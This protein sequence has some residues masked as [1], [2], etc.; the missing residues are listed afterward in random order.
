MKILVL[1]YSF[2]ASAKQITFTDY[3][4]IVVERVLLITNITDNIIIYNFADPAKGGTAATN[5]LTLTYDTGTMS[6]TDKLQIFYDDAATTQPVS[7]TVTANLSATDNT[8]L[9]NIDTKTPALGQALAA[10]STPVVLTA[11]QITTLTPPAQGLTDAQ[12]RATAVP[13]SLASVP[14][15]AVT[16]AGTFAVQSTNQANS[17]VDIG[18]VTINNS[19]GAAAVNIQ[20]GGNTI[21]VDGTV[22]VTNADLTTLAG[23]VSATHMQTDVLTLPANASVNVAQINGVTT[24]MGAGNTGTG[25]QRVTIASDQ[26]AVAS[27]AAINTYV[28]G[29][30]V[31]IGAKADAKSTATDTT[32]VT[33]MQVM[34]QISASVQ[35][36]PSQAVTNAG[37]FATQATLAAETTK[38]IGT[39]NVAASQSIAL[40]AGTAG[41]GKLTANSGV[42]IGDVDVTSIAAGTNLVGDVDIAPRTTGG[43]SVGNYTSGD[44]YTALTATAQVI[45]AGAGKFGGYYIY[46]PNTAA[47]YVEIYNI[48]AASVTV[49]TSTAKLVFCIPAASGANLEL[50]AGIPF[51]TAMSI[52][53]T[54]TGGG[55]TAPTTALEAMIFYK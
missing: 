34:K 23:A 28:D 21:T 4:P 11:A 10:A 49:G 5:V 19:T 1:N 30:I 27:K 24:L 32:A 40:A 25:S 38:V 41:I 42:D 12:L 3:N 36:P 31:T 15:H 29:S 54:T 14:S 46:N 13:V 37:T 45:K 16:N 2:D 50:L 9:D 33:L 26:A 44:T 39:V 22:A 47:T 7:G 17:G 20:D 6:D 35:A 53:A 18:D 43:W 48:A 55:N 51:D 52:A 8:V